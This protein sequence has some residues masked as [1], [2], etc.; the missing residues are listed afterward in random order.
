MQNNQFHFIQG[1]IIHY[2]TLNLQFF[3]S[4][5]IRII[6]T[7]YTNK[8]WKENKNNPPINF[9]IMDFAKWLRNLMKIMDNILNYE[10]K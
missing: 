10:Y 3:W 6:H 9:P 2:M 8:K 4:P 5:L 7:P 1:N